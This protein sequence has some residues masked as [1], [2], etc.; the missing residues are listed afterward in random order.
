MQFPHGKRNKE[1]NKVGRCDAIEKVL[2]RVNRSG[3][4]PYYVFAGGLPEDVVGTTPSITIMQGKNTTVLE[5]EDRVLDFLLVTDSPY[6]SDYQVRA[7]MYGN[8]HYVIQ[9]SCF[10]SQRPLS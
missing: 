9:F 6:S 8:I 5:M 10:R 7:K 3:G 1:T 4:E 2:W